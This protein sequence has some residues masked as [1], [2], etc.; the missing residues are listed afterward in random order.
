MARATATRRISQSSVRK[1]VNFIPTYYER[2]ATFF[3]PVFL[4][5]PYSTNLLNV[6]ES[7][8]GLSS[9]AASARLLL[10]KLERA[11]H[12]YLSYCGEHVYPK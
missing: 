12:Q 7:V 11:A 2:P 1:P 8:L 5:A 9:S 4:R 6:I 3:F 10:K